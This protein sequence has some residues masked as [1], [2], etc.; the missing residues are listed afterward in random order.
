MAL[1]LLKT[2]WCASTSSFIDLC[3]VHSSRDCLPPHLTFPL[4]WELHVVVQMQE[5]MKHTPEWSQKLSDRLFGAMAN[6]HRARSFVLAW[7]TAKILEPL[8][9]L[10]AIAVTPTVARA[11]GRAPAK[12]GDNEAGHGGREIEGDKGSAKQSGR[13]PTEGQGG[14]GV[15]K[16]D[17]GSVGR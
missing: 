12:G 9:L 5:W 11:L 10:A 13:E 14:D 3:Q 17:E 2:V 1:V 7:A 15:K 16:K 6:D 4:Q 8:R